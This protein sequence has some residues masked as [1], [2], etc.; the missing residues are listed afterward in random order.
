[1]PPS[2]IALRSGMA[3]HPMNVIA[4]AATTQ[5]GA[6][7]PS[8]APKIAKANSPIP[9]ATTDPPS[10]RSRR[11]PGLIS[12]RAQLHHDL[13]EVGLTLESY[14]MEVGHRNVA[15]FHAHA[16]G[17]AAERL[18]E[19]GI[20]FVAA[21]AEARRD[22]EGH[23]VAAMGNAARGRPA[24]RAQHV[25]RAQVL[26]QPVAQRAIELQ[27]VAVGP[28]AA[29]AHEVSRILHGKEVFAGGHRLRVVRGERGLQLVVQGIARLLVPEEVVARERLCVRDR[30]VEVEASVGVDREALSRAENPE[31]GLDAAL[32]LGERGAPDL[33]LHDTVAAL[34]VARHLALEL[35]VVLARIVIAAGRVDEHAPGGSAVAVLP[36]EKLEQRQFGDL[37]HRVPHRHVDGAD[38]HGAL[39]MAAGLFV[40]EHARPDAMRVEVV[41][42]LGPE[43]GGIGLEDARDEALAHEHALPVAAVGIESVSDDPGAI[44]NDVGDDG[45]QAQRLLAEIDVRVADWRGD[46][47]R[48]F[49]DLEDLHPPILPG[50]PHGRR[51]ALPRVVR[52]TSNSYLTPIF[53]G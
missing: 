5:R 12:S 11:T 42:A 25:E 37:R 22:V 51:R 27:P 53:A 16:V 15:V 29:V 8:S 9:T 39:A 38:R 34:E 19:I 14:A 10:R 17:E 43:R 30:G 32:V 3:P 31:H 4:T 20:A 28:H 7:K 36:R 46:R 49:P 33:H 18:E 26:D 21:E 35:V 52:V 6:R 2:A 44:A 40:G 47:E 50:E 41:A 13:V 1:M 24:V 45:D 48:L 23:L